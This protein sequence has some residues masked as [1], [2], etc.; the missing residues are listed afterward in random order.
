MAESYSLVE[1]Y[2]GIAEDLGRP[3][4]PFCFLVARDLSLIEP[5]PV[6]YPFHQL[7]NAY[8]HFREMPE[9]SI[10]ELTELKELD[11]PTAD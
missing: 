4:R 10:D 8:S 2:G 1:Q 9:R 5:H 7:W 6:H 11:C 3:A